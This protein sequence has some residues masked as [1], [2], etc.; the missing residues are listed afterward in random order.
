M[1]NY[2]PTA[3]NKISIANAIIPVNSVHTLKQLF[4][5]LNLSNSARSMDD[6]TAGAANY[7]VPNGKTLH[8]I[9]IR[10]ESIGQSTLTIHGGDSD[11][12]QTDLKYT[13]PLTPTYTSIFEMLIDIEITDQ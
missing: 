3:N 5:N 4:L 12:D 11:D 7:Q 6:A 9:G 13:A 2:K 1:T 10:F 8:I